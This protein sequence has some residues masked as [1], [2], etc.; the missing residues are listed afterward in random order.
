M[1]STCF[2]TR[3]KILSEYTSYSDKCLSLFPHS[4]RIHLLF[5]QMSFSLSLFCPNTPLIRTNVFL[6][7]LVLSEY[8]SPVILLKKSVDDQ[9]PPFLL[10]FSV[11]SHPLEEEA[12]RKPP[13]KQAS[14]VEINVF[15]AI[16]IQK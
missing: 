12:W 1:I 13:G 10:S 7:F 14:R 4:V 15:S 6:A 3:P 2:Y 16:P 11:A 5:G 8:T 9:L